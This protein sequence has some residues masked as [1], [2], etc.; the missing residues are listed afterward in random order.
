[1][2]FRWTFHVQTC[3]L[4]SI[5]LAFMENTKSYSYN[6]QIRTHHDK[7]MRRPAGCEGRLKTRHL[8]WVGSWWRWYVKLGDLKATAGNSWD[9]RTPAPTAGDCW[10]DDESLC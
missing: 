1:M 2:I 6:L 3:L 10:Q 4:P 8:S 7:E 5:M 9:Q